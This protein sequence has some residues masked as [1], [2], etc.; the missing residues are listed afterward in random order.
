MKTYKKSA[1]TLLELL[2]AMTIAI[3]VIGAAFSSIGSIYYGQKS[4]RVSQDFYKETKFIKQRL[5]D[6]SRD[7]TIDYD[8][9]FVTV[10]PDPDVCTAFDDNQQPF[11]VD[12]TNHDCH[13]E[14]DIPPTSNRCNNNATNRAILTYK[15]I[16]Y[17]DTDSDDQPDRN[18]GGRVFENGT[19]PVVDDCAQAF[20]ERESNLIVDFAGTKMPALFLIDRDREIRRAF[21]KSTYKASVQGAD[22]DLGRIEIQAQLS[23][24][25]DEDGIGDIWG[26]SDEDEDG[27]LD[28]GDTWLEWYTGGLTDYCRM[29][30]REST[31]TGYYDVV[32]DLTNREFCEQAHDWVPMTIRSLNIQSLDLSVTPDRDPYLAFRDDLVQTHPRTTIR[33]TTSLTD[34]ISFGF[35]QGIQITSQTTAS[36]RVFGNTRK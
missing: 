21:R 26:P 35:E 31:S 10:G 27:S 2:V 30:R 25:I 15:N 9:Y 16:F 7:N 19:T 23:A 34:P 20:Y 14:T 36:S 32:G 24:D 13:S 22:V 8:R 28:V 6:L 18:M 29:G 5:V 4:L 3:I 1:F 12:D 17:W 33:M 11:L